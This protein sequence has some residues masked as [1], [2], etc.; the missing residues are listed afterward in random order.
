M[1][2]SFILVMYLFN[3][4]SGLVESHIVK[5]YPPDIY[6]EIRC[7]TDEKN[8]NRLAQHDRLKNI[9]VCERSKDI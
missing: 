9:F 3:F 4:D 7:K 1:G 6:T 8:Y 5:S 2:S